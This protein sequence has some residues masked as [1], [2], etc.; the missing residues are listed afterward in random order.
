MH[1]VGYKWSVSNGEGG[2]ASEFIAIAPSVKMMGRWLKLAHD[3][4]CSNANLLRW[5]C[6]IELPLGC[7]CA[8]IVEF[9][10]N[11]GK[12]TVLVKTC[13][14]CK[15]DFT[16]AGLKFEKNQRRLLFTR[17]NY[18]CTERLRNDRKL[19]KNISAHLC[20]LHLPSEVCLVFKLEKMV[21]GLKKAAN[22]ETGPVIMI[23]NSQRCINVNGV[24]Y[25]S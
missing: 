4:C 5:R 12:K 23:I 13:F 1:Y 17:P 20:R 6:G 14:Y 9:G 11:S 10:K 19:K 25:F 22:I 8:C 21:R 15:P 18:S 24:A 2:K 3:G 7:G 16:A